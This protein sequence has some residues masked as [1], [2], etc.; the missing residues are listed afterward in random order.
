MYTWTEEKR[1]TSIII[2]QLYVT[3]MYNSSRDGPVVLVV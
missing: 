3:Y 1:S 2:V